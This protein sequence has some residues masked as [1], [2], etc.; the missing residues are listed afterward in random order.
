MGSP[1][2]V[3]F[4]DGATD[5]LPL[6]EIGPLFERH[7]IFPDRIN[8]EFV[9]HIGQNRL[10]MRV[11]ERGSGETM[12]CGTGACAAAVAAVL[13]GLC[14]KGTDIAVQC[15][16]GELVINY[17]DKTVFMTGGCITVFEG[18]VEV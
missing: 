8:T 7:K 14:D 15:L 13:N 16:G 17:T 2:A 9:E 18:V 12:A 5:S 3:V 11:W 10:K 4:F 1:H 6:H